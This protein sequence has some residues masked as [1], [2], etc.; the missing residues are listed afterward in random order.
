MAVLG[1]FFYMAKTRFLQTNH[2]PQAELAESL[3]VNFQTSPR[4]KS[5]NWQIAIFGSKIIIKEA[6]VM[7]ERLPT[8]YYPFDNRGEVE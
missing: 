6:A 3:C 7:I 1:D 4:T 5:Q 2:F 8:F